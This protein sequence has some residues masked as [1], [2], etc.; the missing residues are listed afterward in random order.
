MTM[1]FTA[2]IYR[3]A[4][5]ERLLEAGELHVVGAYLMAHFLA[6]LAVEC[7]LRAY[8]L[9]IAEYPSQ[10]EERHD[11]FRLMKAARYDRLFPS[12]KREE[13]AS[14][15][16]Y[17]QLHWRNN[18]RFLTSEGLRTELVRAKLFLRIRKGDLLREHSRRMLIAAEM[19]VGQGVKKWKNF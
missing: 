5:E 16:T 11:L 15:L 8:R 7:I 18:H 1:R 12:A 6:G 10:F 4:A 19:V 3:D 17:V 9:R 13:L 14:A 2:E